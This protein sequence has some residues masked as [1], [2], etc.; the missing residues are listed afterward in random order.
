[1]KKTDNLLALT[2]IL[3]LPLA[4]SAVAENT[5]HT[6]PLTKTEVG[7][8]LVGDST[9]STW[10]VDRPERGWGQMIPD[11]FDANARF[12][13]RAAPG[14]SA[15]SF[16]SEGRWA[17][18]L[19]TVGPDDYVLI[20]FGH[21]DSHDPSSPEATDPF[22]NYQTYLEQYIA[23]TRAKGAIPI[24][25]T[26]MYRRSFDDDGNLLPYLIDDD[27]G[28][29]YNLQPYAEAMRQVARS[30]DVT[31]IDLFS[32]SGDL[33]R[34]L[35]AEA[36]ARL[37][38][39]NDRAHWNHKGATCMAFLVSRGISK[40]GEALKQHLL[41][42][43]TPSEFSPASTA[44]TADAPVVS[45]GARSNRDF[46]VVKSAT[47]ATV[48]YSAKDA[49][50]VEI[51]ANLFAKDVERVSGVHPSVK[52]SVSDVQGPLVLIG[53]LGQSPEIDA[54]A[55][56]GKI[57]VSAIEGGWEQY[58]IEVVERPYPG[59]PQALVIAGSDRR[60]AA[61]GVFSLSEE[62]GVSPWYWWADSPTES[63]PEI[64]VSATPLT[65]K[66]PSVPYRGI[67]INDEDWG[68]QEWAEKNF[69]SGPEEVK[70][71]GPKT[72][73]K[74]F[75]LLLRLK[76]NLVWPAMHPSTKA[77][78]YYPENKQVADD[79]AIVM[80]SSHAEPM[81]RNNVDEWDKKKYG[82]WSPV[83][84]L[85]SISN[86]WEQ[87][88]RE[89]GQYENVF[90]VGIRGIHDSGMT[91]GGSLGERRERLEGIIDLQRGLLEK[92]VDADPSRVPQLFCPYKEVLTL[93]RSGM[94]LPNDITIAWP[95]DNHGYIRQL[96]N[97]AERMRAGG[98]G[99]YYHISYWGRPHD[100]LWLEST[101]PA[102]IW[103]E[104]TKAYDLGARHLWV[105][106]VGDI[107]PLEAG[108][109]LFL[110]LAWNVDAY[111]P[112]VQREFLHGF[113]AQQFGQKYADAVATLKDQYFRLSSIRRPEHIGFNRIYPD[114]PIQDSYWSHSPENDEAQ[115]MLDRWIKLAEE[116]EAF[117]DELPAEMRT[118]YFQLIE[119]PARAASAMVE[120]ILWAEKA[121]R[122]GSVEQARKAKAALQ[123]I[124]KLTEEYNS[125]NGGKWREMMDYS[126][127]DLPVFGMPFT[128]Q[129]A[130]NEEKA[131]HQEAARGIEIDPTSFE[132]ARGHK[133]AT[134]QVI[135]G[136]GPRGVAIAVLPHQ[137][138]PTLRT[139][140]AVR[141]RAPVAEYAIETDQSGEAEI[142]VE[143][144]P[145]HPFTLEH[146]VLTAVSINDGDPVFV[147][148]DRG[149]IG[150]YD[151]KWQANV[152]RHAMLGSVNL[153]VPEGSFT[154]KL[155]AADRA[156]VVQKITLTF[157]R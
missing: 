109:N 6:A 151:E 31:L 42:G 66:A 26:P 146:E 53:T 5:V 23:D 28:H 118:A 132:G 98:N 136:L 76:A 139:P 73:A 62:M 154:L 95:D 14:R 87:R 89:N 83:E 32:M 82:E 16:I 77:F 152:L 72:Y 100:Y 45:E 134:W 22:G 84:N 49:K 86:Y 91:G 126:P 54:L 11:Y 58:R 21:N 48:V 50:V 112:D 120:K 3:L 35:G 59:V 145:T 18:I 123:R 19:E 25:V 1:M 20:Q 43:V 108:M 90:T 39:P 29:F 127:R 142:L 113:Y 103:L 147:H 117:A 143:A 150:E 144:L 102:H 124:E 88:V 68:L 157:A 13:N 15:K 37:F 129:Q 78:N 8:V 64:H 111:G 46:A 79:Y 67:F 41:P 153:R 133:A 52:T 101:S 33:L 122:T 27:G 97:T 104:M 63:M 125:H 81:L 9:V 44:E 138:V 12:A 7:V 116:T 115:L 24:L 119:Y 57:D 130:A 61:Y 74:I 85:Q 70:D 40:S 65:S 121:R 131:P 75:E 51:A 155:W 4:A 60:G 71:M 137:D 55:A 56:G 148:F 34:E 30:T 105:L 149:G 92:H 38:A 156:L 36:S 135:N 47:A 107:K 93:Y 69:E 94:E 80:G 96:P 10:G 114:T 106:N 99:V 17:K 128:A 140:E 110:D 141:E 2:A